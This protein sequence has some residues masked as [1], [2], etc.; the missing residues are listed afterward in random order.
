MTDATWTWTRVGPREWQV[1]IDTRPQWQRAEQWRS[2]LHFRIVWHEVR[3]PD[4]VGDAF[5]SIIGWWPR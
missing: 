2:P 3:D 5:R 1:S 4:P